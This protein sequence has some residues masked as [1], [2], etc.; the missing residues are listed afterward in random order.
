MASD[1]ASLLE[2]RTAVG[3]GSFSYNLAAVQE[4]A[5]TRLERGAA[6]LAFKLRPAFVAVEGTVARAGSTAVVLRGIDA[7]EGIGGGARVM[8]SAVLP[9]P[10]YAGAAVCPVGYVLSLDPPANPGTVKEFAAARLGACT[11]CGPGTY[12]LNPLGGRLATT[13]D[14]HEPYLKPM[15][16]PNSAG[17]LSASWLGGG[18]PRCLD[19]PAAADCSDGGAAV[20]FAVGNWTVAG[21]M[22]LLVGCPQGHQVSPPSTA[23]V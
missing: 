5:I 16:A 18:G 14:T 23:L 2:V 1:S 4:G 9:V 11:L 20:R 7:A 3:E 6:R 13:I 19:C 17:S 22:Y 12:S 8:S 10:F 15:T 21:G